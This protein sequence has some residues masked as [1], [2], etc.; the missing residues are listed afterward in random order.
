MLCVG[1]FTANVAAGILYTLLVGKTAWL[2]RQHGP[3]D[4]T[5]SLKS[6]P[7]G[8]RVRVS[9]DNRAGSGE[10]GLPPPPSSVDRTLVLSGVSASNTGAHG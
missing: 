6:R 3:P 9:L 1:N 8:G 7:H 2:Q 4:R 5:R 10:E